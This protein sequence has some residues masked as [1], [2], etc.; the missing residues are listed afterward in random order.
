[1]KK[2]LSVVIAFASIVSSLLSVVLLYK[3][4]LGINIPLFMSTFLGILLLVGIYGKRITGDLLLHVTLLFLISIPF[5]IT[6][7]MP[8]KIALLLFIFYEILISLYSFTQKI[9][10]FEFYKYIVAPIEVGVMSLFGAIFPLA[11]L[12]KIKVK[13][14]MYVL[15]ILLG[16]VLAIPFLGLFTLLLV[17]ADLVFKDI[18]SGLFSGNFFSDSAIITVWFLVVA[19]ILLGSLYYVVRLKSETK[20]EKESLKE[21]APSSR[22]L[23][24]GSTIL[25]LVELLFLL[26]N[27]IQLTYLFGGE[28]LI[29]GGEFTYSEYARRG[30]FELVAVSVI[31]LILIGVVF[32]LKKTKTAFQSRIIRVIGVV[33]ILELMPM[34]TSAFYRLYMYENAYG[35]TRLRIYSHL[36]TVFLF[37]VFIWFLIKIVSNLSE[38][39]FIYGLFLTMY[40]SMIIIGFVNTDAIITKYN[41]SRYNHTDN[42]TK[43]LDLAYLHSLSYDAVPE[44]V[45]LYKNTNDYDLKVEI[46]FYL[47]SFYGRIIFDENRRDLRAWR[48]RQ[49]V[50]KNE[51]DR[52]LD[53]V[54]RDSK[55][56]EQKVIDSIDNN[57]RDYMY[58]DEYYNC[59]QSEMKIRFVDTHGDDVYFDQVKIMKYTDPTYVVLNIT[60]YDCYDLEDG[61]YFFV[62]V[63]DRYMGNQEVHLVNITDT[64]GEIVIISRNDVGNYNKI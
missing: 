24:E 44:L 13:A 62:M 32:K 3:S 51:L 4:G 12:G 56:Y 1:M 6:T 63:K 30:F 59:S 25:V 43:E 17:S 28:S 2:N 42:A 7:S 55:I 38:K 57:S 34:T 31:A 11:K 8:I 26:F 37:I 5:A 49:T 60:P 15:R 16:I 52:V 47:K 18:V 14:P 46:A 53:E 61:T 22:F 20:K 29:T 35:F 58:Y 45:K 48:Y 36:F 39:I 21:T 41:I 27:V 54:N 23:V 40:L 33:G 10:T 64:S 50:A 19:W 9:W